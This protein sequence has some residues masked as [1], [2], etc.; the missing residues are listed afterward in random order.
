MFNNIFCE[1]YHIHYNAFKFDGY[2]KLVFQGFLLEVVE[3]SIWSRFSEASAD[4]CFNTCPL[5]LGICIQY[6]SA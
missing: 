1:I 5:R 3:I 2:I 6:Y 4:S